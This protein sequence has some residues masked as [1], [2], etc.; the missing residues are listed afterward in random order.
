MNITST[1]TGPSLHNFHFKL[2]DKLK[3]S[4]RAS[5]DSFKVSHTYHKETC[6]KSWG[7]TYISRHEIPVKSISYEYEELDYSPPPETQLVSTSKQ[8][9]FNYMPVES[10]Q[11]E[12]IVS[13]S[14]IGIEGK[15]I[16]IE[17]VIDFTDKT[18]KKYII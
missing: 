14:Q 7:I 2:P 6:I 18:A 3:P 9:S 16:D 5:G 12:G 11:Q 1:S 8:A 15:Y 13:C 17:A 10:T 4:L